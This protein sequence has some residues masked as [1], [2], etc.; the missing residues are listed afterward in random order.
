MR[1]ALTT[2][3]LVLAASTADAQVF[4]RSRQQYSPPSNCPNGVCPAASSPGFPD[5]SRGLVMPS[6]PATGEFELWLEN[7]QLVYKPVPKVMESPTPA[8][9]KELIASFGA[10][11]AAQRMHG[12]RAYRIIRAFSERQLADEAVKRGYK[13]AEART[14]ARELVGKLTDA[15]I[16]DV[17][18]KM[19]GV[20][21]GI[22]DGV[23]GDRIDNIIRIID[24]I[25]KLLLLFL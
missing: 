16:D 6:K 3:I 14:K 19:A 12:D 2:L 21:E 22:G 23:V 5:N 13:P 18:V 11:S 20:S 7:G 17:G 8:V 24:A 10:K 1:L 25:M 9:P 15:N 4:G